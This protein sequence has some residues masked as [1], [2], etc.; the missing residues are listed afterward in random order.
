MIFPNENEEMILEVSAMPEFYD[1]GDIESVLFVCHDITKARK[2][3]EIISKKNKSIQDSINYAYYIQSSLMPTEAKLQSIIPNSFMLYMPKDIVSGD[4]PFLYRDKDNVYIGAMD[5]TGHGVPGALMSIIG[6]FCKMRSSMTI[7][8][9]MP[10]RYLPNCIKMLSAHF[11]RKMK[12]AKLMM[13]WMPL[14]VK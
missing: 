1:N 11:G 7:V 6:H 8:K 5:C 14:S 9:K 2:R 3:E 10:D 4:Y 12:T 13:E